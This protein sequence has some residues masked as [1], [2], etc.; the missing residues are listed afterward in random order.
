MTIGYS[1]LHDFP[2]GQ[3]SEKKLEK[4]LRFLSLTIEQYFL[5]DFRR[6]QFPAN[7]TL[8]TSHIPDSFQIFF[9]SGDF[10][11]DSFRIV[12]IALSC[13]R[14]HDLTL[15]P[16]R[17]RVTPPAYPA[18]EASNGCKHSKLKG[19]PWQLQTHIKFLW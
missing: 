16:I 14:H 18:P 1:F 10:L 13:F 15:T 12:R 7:Q 19:S 17:L 4:L 8:K 6:G 2:R 11:P 3:F 9:S 5:H